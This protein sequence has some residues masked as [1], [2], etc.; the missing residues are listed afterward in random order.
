MSGQGPFFGD[1]L[2]LG[3]KSKLLKIGRKYARIKGN[4][5]GFP[6][7]R[8]VE[9][10]AQRDNCVGAFGC[11]YGGCGYTGRAFAFMGG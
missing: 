8:D 9:E 6:S 4:V 7:Q 3:R 11:V 10:Q 2:G 5:R 1:V